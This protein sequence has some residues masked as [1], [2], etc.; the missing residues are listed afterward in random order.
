MTRERGPCRQGGDPQGIDANLGQA[1]LPDDERRAG[2]QFE[3]RRRL[4]RE[5]QLRS[6]IS[7]ELQLD[8]LPID[9][10]RHDQPPQALLQ[11]LI[12]PLRHLAT[13]GLARHARR[14]APH[15][16]QRQEKQQADPQQ[17]ARHDTSGIARAVYHGRGPRAHAQGL[18]GPRLALCYTVMAWILSDPLA[19]SAGT[20]ARLALAFGLLG[21]LWLAVAW[22]LAA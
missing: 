15:E 13:R 7:A 21:L 18:L 10:R 9:L 3:L 20:P 14:G 8:R 16:A 5:G 6:Q 2:R 17:Q 19:L 12:R 22:A 1:L 4:W 11:R